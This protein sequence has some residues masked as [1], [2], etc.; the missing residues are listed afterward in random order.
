MRSG[1]RD[2]IESS[3]VRMRSARPARMEGKQQVRNKAG[4]CGPAVL[5]EML[6][7]QP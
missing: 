4:Y 7:K 1:D 5:S 6:N 2:E 3:K